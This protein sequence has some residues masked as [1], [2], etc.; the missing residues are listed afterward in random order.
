[1]RTFPILVLALAFLAAGGLLTSVEGPGFYPARLLLLTGVAGL[2]WSVVR[3]WP[4]LRLFAARMRT[5]A[6]PGPALTWVLLAAVLLVLAVGLNLRPTRFDLTS[7]GLQSLSPASKR[8]LAGIHTRVEMIGVYRDGSDDQAHARDIL[9]VYQTDERGIHARL[10]D[11]ERSPDEARRLGIHF[12]SGVLIQADSSSEVVT[13]LTENALTEGI[14]RAANPTRPLIGLVLSHGEAAPD[15]SPI[16]HLRELLAEAGFRQAR[17]DLTQGDVPPTIKALL[18]VGPES[19]LLPGE[20]A[21]L[22]R[23]EQRGG[24]LG[25][26]LDP[27]PS[28]GLTS[29]LAAQGILVDGRLIRDS[30]PLT[31]SAGL[32]PETIAVQSLGEHPITKGLTAAILL[33]GA[34]RVGLSSLPVW[35]SNGS[36]ILR[37]AP[38]ALL[39]GSRSD[40]TGAAAERAAKDLPLGVALERDV[41][42]PETRALASGLP[43]ERRVARLVVIGDSDF[44]RD[45]T[46]DLYGN[47]AFATRVIG[48]L[49]ER[50]YLLDVPR[51]NQ[52]GTPLK[53]GLT[54]LRTIFYLVEILPPV[55]M[56]GLGLLVWARRR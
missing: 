45:E 39:E 12:T 18:I 7:R 29:W 56:L 28:T 27:E 32:G 9:D 37:S 16:T 25:L 42:N 50:D 33:R 40:T 43:P 31:R 20:V 8:A 47:R 30:G 24:R 38:S 35:G 11:P 54:G 2:I 17:I 41:R 15:R 53:V 46:L 48:W 44:L 19:P 3:A 14:L 10:L 21:V 36:E 52:A 4:T 49:G 51:P 5:V 22:D 34:T 13:D 6:E 55:L 1:M 23:F 26:F